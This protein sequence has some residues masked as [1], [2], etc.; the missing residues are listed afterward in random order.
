MPFLAGFVVIIV[1]RKPNN[2]GLLHGMGVVSSSPHWFR[3]NPLRLLKK[4]TLSIFL[5]LLLL[6]SSTYEC[7]LKRKR[8]NWF[9][10][11]IT[12][13]PCVSLIFLY[14]K[15]LGFRSLAAV[16]SSVLKKK[17]FYGLLNDWIDTGRYMNGLLSAN[18]TFNRDLL[19]FK[20][21]PHGHYRSR[22]FLCVHLP[23]VTIS[24]SGR[25]KERAWLFLHPPP[26]LI[27]WIAGV[28][29]QLISFTQTRTG[30]HFW[31]DAV[32]EE[33]SSSSQGDPLC[34]LYYW[35]VL[36][37]E[38]IITELTGSQEKKKKLLCS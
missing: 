3:A 35:R 34:P 21:S 6:L 8:E 22:I 13:S 36:R 25:G 20:S 14:R 1:I 16:P 23:R 26:P 15:E 17:H 32:C 27:P 19:L 30:E 28:I 31:C 7:R 29:F 2:C 12:G 18:V 37:N 24:A 33:S 5:L 11:T 4:K 38:G 9:R 10:N